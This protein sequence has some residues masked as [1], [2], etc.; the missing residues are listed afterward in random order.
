MNPRLISLAIPTPEGAFLA[1]YSSAGLARLE[2]P[3]STRPNRARPPGR[4]PASSTVQTW[5]R[6]AS[7]ALHQALAGRDP[8]KLPPLDWSGS[9]EFQQQVWRVMR[10]IP[11]GETLGYGD[12]AARLGR[13]NASRS[14]GGACGRNPIP[15]LVP[16]HRVLA[17]HKKLGGFSGGLA[18]KRR[19]LQLEGIPTA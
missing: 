9:T 14:V 5:H 1:H 11:C 19:L 13:P 3:R 17:A 12:I 18:W 2:F 10:A 4:V 7:A 15:V 8:G 16:C 6:A